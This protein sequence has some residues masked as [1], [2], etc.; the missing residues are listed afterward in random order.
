MNSMEYIRVVLPKCV[1]GSLSAME[2]TIDKRRAECERRPT[3]RGLSLMS[4][5]ISAGKADKA[6]VAR[7]V[8]S[9]PH[10]TPNACGKYS[11]RTKN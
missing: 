9:R 10:I 11:R 3:A 6:N 2:R 5:A 4:R 1:I 8:R 7:A